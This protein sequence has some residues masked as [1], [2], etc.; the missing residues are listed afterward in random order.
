MHGMHITS[1]RT[2]RP[3]DLCLRLTEGGNPAAEPAKPHVELG[4]Q[5]QGSGLQPLQAEGRGR[6]GG[7]EVALGLSLE[8]PSPLGAAGTSEPP[9]FCL[10][11]PF[12]PGTWR[13]MASLCKPAVSILGTAAATKRGLASALWAPARAPGHCH[14]GTSTRH[15]AR[16]VPPA[17]NVPECHGPCMLVTSGLWPRFSSLSLS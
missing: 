1:P 7:P 2:K 5:P 17:W 12:K 11:G 4:P 8:I 6:R 15:F 13:T 9:L 3:W 14:Q 16:A 10:N